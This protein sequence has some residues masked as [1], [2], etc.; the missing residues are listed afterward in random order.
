MVACARARSLH[1]A[2][3]LA[4]ASSSRSRASLRAGSKVPP[5]QT[6]GF[7]DGVGK[8]RDLGAHRQVLA[9]RG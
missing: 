8:L 1:S 2:G 3:S 6:Q 7:S 4:A 9:V 5:E